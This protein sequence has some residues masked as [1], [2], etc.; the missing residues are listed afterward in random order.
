MGPSVYQTMYYSP[1]MTVADPRVEFSRNVATGYGGA[2]YND[3]G[4]SSKERAH[5]HCIIQFIA[6]SFGNVSSSITFT[7]N[8]AQQ[9]GHA[10]YATPIYGCNCIQQTPFN[11]VTLRGNVASYFT[12]TP[13]PQD[14]NDIQVLS[15][16]TY[17]QLCNCSD[18][19]LCNV[20]GQHERKATT[21]PGGT[22][23]PNFV[24][25]GN[26]PADLIRLP[27]MVRRTKSRC[28]KWSTGP[29]QAAQNGPTLPVLVR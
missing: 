12:I 13:L 16:P 9:G 20:V 4:P 1:S 2:I 8:H 29:F 27:E 7:D 18:P 22:V 28:L 6:D 10:V 14:L 17:V 24:L 25:S 19:D 5:F 15:F 3:G 26:G 23:T 11:F 21:Y